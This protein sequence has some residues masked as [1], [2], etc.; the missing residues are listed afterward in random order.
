MGS[1]CCRRRKWLRLYHKYLCVLWL[2]VISSDVNKTVTLKTKTKTVTLK[3]KT[4][5]KTLTLKTKT[6]TEA[7]ATKNYMNKTNT[8]VCL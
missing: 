4:K 8:L 5:T 7:Y 2:A 3:T 6:K 1:Q